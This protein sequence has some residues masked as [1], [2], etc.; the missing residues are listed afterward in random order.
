VGDGGGGGAEGRRKGLSTKQGL[1]CPTLNS[2]SGSDSGRTI[3]TGRLP[4]RI[5][6]EL[7]IFDR[8][9]VLKSDDEHDE[10]NR[11]D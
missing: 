9:Y 8:E 1:E 11:G 10:I 3:I 7:P 6:Y 2:E 4:T 5:H